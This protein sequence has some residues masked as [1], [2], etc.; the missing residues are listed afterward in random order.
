MK[1]SAILFGVNEYHGSPLKNAVND[2]RALSKKLA[3]LG[4]ETKCFLDVDSETM[5]RELVAFKS[6]LA[7]S[8][9]ALFFF[10]GHGIQCK[11]EN[12]LATKSTSFLTKVHVNTLL[13]H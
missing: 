12:Y 1:K 7:Q 9:V 2:A 10:A 4:F 13:L 6:D 3:E 11:G 5:N 8:S